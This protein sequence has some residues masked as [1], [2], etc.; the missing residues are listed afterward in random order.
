GENLEQPVGHRNFPQSL[1]GIL[2]CLDENTVKR[3]TE[4]SGGAS[5]EKIGHH[6]P[7]MH[8]RRIAPKKS[9]GQNDK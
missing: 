9:R 1:H 5:R 2:P 8:Y 7:P 4:A 6:R 3:L